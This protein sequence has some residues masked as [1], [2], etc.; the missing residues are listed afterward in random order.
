MSLEEVAEFLLV[1][2]GGWGVPG[3][4]GGASFE[5]VGD[6]D[7]VLLLVGGGQNVGTL[8][9]LIEESEDVY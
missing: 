1:L 3:D 8:D 2:I 6:I 7:A 5:E 4:V 9:G